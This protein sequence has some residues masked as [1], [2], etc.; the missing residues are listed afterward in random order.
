M[1]FAGKV[2]YGAV[3]E[4]LAYKVP[5][6]FVRRDYFNEEPFLRNMLEVQLVIPELV[7]KIINFISFFMIYLFLV[8]NSITRVVWR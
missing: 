7:Y 5:F 2:G 4:S 6:I 1:I 8:L 3:S